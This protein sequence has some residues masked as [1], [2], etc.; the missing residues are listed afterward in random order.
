[1]NHINASQK[2]FSFVI[3]PKN[4]LINLGGVDRMQ[5]T[6]SSTENFAKYII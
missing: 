5:I 6:S 4:F 1:M 2:L 3:V